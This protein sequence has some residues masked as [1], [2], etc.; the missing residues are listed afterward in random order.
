[1]FS[2]LRKSG[3]GIGDEIGRIELGA[4]VLRVQARADDVDADA[5][6]GRQRVAEPGIAEGAREAV[7]VGVEVAEL[8]V[9]A[10]RRDAT[11]AVAADRRGVV[12]AALRAADADV[13][14][15]RVVAADRRV[16]DDARAGFAA[17]GEDLDHAADGIGAVEARRRPAQD[18]D[19]V[20]LRQAE[21][22]E[23]DLAGGRRADLDAV[24]QDDRAARSRA[25]QEVP[26]ALSRA[27]AARE[28]QAGDAAQQVLDRIGAAV[29]DRLV[30][31]ADDVGGAAIESLRLARAGDDYR[32]ERALRE[33]GGRQ[34]DQ[35]TET[36]QQLERAQADLEVGHDEDPTA[37]CAA[38]PRPHADWPQPRLWP[39]VGRYPG[40]WTNPGDLPEGRGL[41]WRVRRDRHA[42]RGSDVAH[43]TVAGAAQAG[44]TSAT[45]IFCFPFNC[46]GRAAF[47]STNGAILCSGARTRRPSAM[48][49]RVRV[50]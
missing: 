21:R 24:D 1:M 33:R 31:D 27:A 41:Q 16:A 6:P 49:R 46:D 28:L 12:E 11:R 30:V 8:I 42:P 17:A 18:L 35:E 36:P 4:V 2:R 3:D 15:E 39:L 7:G 19:V 47:T 26:R 29:A 9:R 34:Q 5:M 38:S 48:A 22:F 43:L 44:S 40:W 45:P 37:A 14:L 13:G 20:D 32:I 25:A 50:R 23:L 10:D